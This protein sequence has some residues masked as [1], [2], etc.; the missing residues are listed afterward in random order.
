MTDLHTAVQEYIVLR[1]AVGFKL[2][3]VERQLL[4]FVEFLR[5]RGATRVTCELALS[6][7]TLPRDVKPGWWK[8]RLSVVRCFAR[9]LSALDPLT[10]VPT[11]DL[12]P[13]LNRG[14]RRAVPYPYSEGEVAAL[15]AAARVIRS[16]M[17]AATCETL[18]GLLATTGMRVGESLRLDR[19]DVDDGRGLL[20]VR[21]SKFARSR[22]IPLHESSLDAL[23]RYGRTRDRHFPTP[24]SPSLL[25][26]KAGGRLTYRPVLWLFHRLVRQA[27][28]GPRS[29]RCRP[30]LHDLRHR[31]AAITLED[32]Y[33]SGVD[34]PP[35]LPLLSTYL[36]HIDPQSTYWYLSASPQLLT[37]TAQRL[38]ATLGTPT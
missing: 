27:G 31:F 13:R 28:L 15:M 29:D 30:R 16:A 2:D 10:Q 24:K 34:V 6:W 25:I 4:D 9:Y 7:G 5:S 1:H 38:E 19:D 8:T 12:L 35:R 3:R 23:H 11:T 14:S 17:T 36:G 37:A 18:I 26:N 21:H 20:I 32:W 22:E 33:R